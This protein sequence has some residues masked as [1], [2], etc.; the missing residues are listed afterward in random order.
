MDDLFIEMFR[1]R[2][3][4]DIARFERAVAKDGSLRNLWR[5]N[6]DA[7]AAARTIEFVALANHRKAIRAE[8]ARYVERFRTAQLEAVRS[9]LGAAGIEE[10]ALP[11]EVALLAMMGLSQVL[12]LEETMG[13]S[14]GHRTTTAFVHRLI[15]SLEGEL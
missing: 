3:D 12:A 11:P 7:R 2:A 6:T 8:I 14:S 9:S 13:V 1:R 5:L 10:D 4:I 15:A